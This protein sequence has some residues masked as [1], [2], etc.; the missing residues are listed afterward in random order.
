MEYLKSNILK[1]SEDIECGQSEKLQS[2]NYD[3]LEKVNYL[4]ALSIDRLKDSKL[5][6]SSCDNKGTFKIGEYTIKEVEYFQNK[7]ESIYQL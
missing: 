5:K 7:I 6:R 3:M 2:I 1:E 4:K